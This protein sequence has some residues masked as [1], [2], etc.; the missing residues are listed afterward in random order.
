LRCFVFTERE[1]GLLR[2][3][4]GR[5]VESGETR[6]VFSAIRR[7]VPGLRGDLELM[8]RVVWELRRR[9]RWGGRVT[10][11]TGL[12]CAL[13]AAESGLTRLRGG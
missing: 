9:G 12:G 5:G 10:G 3:W 1:R 6:K 13:R 11:G 4:L 8:L 2:E 7:N